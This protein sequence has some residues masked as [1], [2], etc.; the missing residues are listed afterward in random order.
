[1][2]NLKSKKTSKLKVD[3]PG[4]EKES[5]KVRKQEIQKENKK[6]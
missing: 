3:V 5:K 6:K 2:S 4:N 1:M